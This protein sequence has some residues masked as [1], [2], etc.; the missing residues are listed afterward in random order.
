MANFRWPRTFSSLVNPDFRWFTLSQLAGTTANWMEAIVRSVIV[1]D[2]SGSALMLGIVNVSKTVPSL[3][4]GFVGGVLADRVNRKHLLIASQLTSGGA[5]G[6]LGFLVLANKIQVWHFVVAALVEGFVSSVQHP[7]R[8]ALI[9]TVVPREHL[10]NA[11]ALSGGIWSASRTLGPTLAGGAAAAAGLSAALFL[12][13]AFYVTGALCLR[14][15]TALEKS[16][17]PEEQETERGHQRGRGRT[18]FLDDF[19]GYKYLWENPVV[20]W[21]AVLAIV[22][23]IFGT[24]HRLLAPVFAREVLH[25][26]AAGIGLLL[27]APGAGALVATFMVAT[28]SHVRGKGWLCLIGVV[29]HG[30]GMIVYAH[31]TV[32]WLSLTG[33]IVHGFAMTAYHSLN[34]TLVQIHTSDEY[35]GRVMAVYAVDRALHPVSGLAIALM[36]DIW[37]AP[38]AVTISGIGCIAM[39][40]WVGIKSRTIRR[41]D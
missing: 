41:L 29:V 12:E 20:G 32:L 1:Y 3:I 8:Q 21:L 11:I 40:L 14:R 30:V 34:Q 6:T 37:T 33:L 31:S 2:L 4:F 16:D 39:A 36:A 38:I 10:M 24:G 17:R 23:V 27:A 7:A 18:G 26:G 25:L 13:A 19:R 5:A 9:P 15:V 35:R 28:S 22:P